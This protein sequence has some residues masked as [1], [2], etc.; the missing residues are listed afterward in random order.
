ML[1]IAH[2]DIK[3]DNILLVF[4][5][6]LGKYSYKVI[7]FG[8]STQKDSDPIFGYT[9]HYADP[10]MLKYY[11][12]FDKKVGENRLKYDIYSIGILFVEM[13]GLGIPGFNDWKNNFVKREQQILKNLER[14]KESFPISYHLAQNM[15]QYK[16]QNRKTFSHFLKKLKSFEMKAPDERVFFKPVKRISE[17][18]EKSQ[19][20]MIDEV[21][22]IPELVNKSQKIM[23]DDGN[24]RAIS[25]FVEKSQKLTIGIKRISE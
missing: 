7:E 13:M 8:C 14:I 20:A 15:L 22:R 23:I 25:E 21:K 19:Q 4:D 24:K 16:P 17:L 6:R 5:E 2:M 9:F 12:T 11:H 1:N 18:V 3:P 10:E